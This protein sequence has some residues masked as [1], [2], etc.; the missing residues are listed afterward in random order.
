[1]GRK[2]GPGD[3]GGYELPFFDEPPG[4]PEGKANAC[5]R[6][7]LQLQSRTCGHRFRPHAGPQFLRQT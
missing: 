4:R 6:R 7:W 3:L 1:M 2:R 5:R